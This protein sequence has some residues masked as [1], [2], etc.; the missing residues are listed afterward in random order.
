MESM[1]SSVITKKAYGYARVSTPEQV[2]DH[3]S[4]DNQC[5]RIEEYAKRNNIEIVDW[6]IEEGESAKTAART[7]LH[8]MLE[9]CRKNK[10]NIDHVIVYNVSRISRNLNSFMNDIGSRLS[11][12]GITLRSTMEVIDETPQGKL[13]LNIALSIHQFDNDIKAQTAH[14]N[15]SEVALKG[16][17]ITRAPIGYKIRKVPIG[18]ISSDGHRKER[19]ILVPD[20]SN[21]LA[22]KLTLVLNQFA[23]SNGYMSEADAWRLAVKIGIT[24]PR[25][26]KPIS[27]SCF[28]RLLRQ[29][30]YA[31]Y[32]NSKLVNGELHKLNFNGLISLETHNRIQYILNHDKRIFTPSTDDMY[33]LKGLLICSKCGKYLLG[34]APTSG[35]KK[36]SPRYHCRCKGHGSMAV[37][38]AHSLYEEL[39]E[40]ITPTDGTVKLFKE[41]VS[42]TAAKYLGA[43]NKEIERLN[44]QDEEINQNI[45]RTLN[46]FL[47][48]KSINQ[49][50]KDLFIE[51]LNKERA[52]IE[53]EIE[54]QKEIRQLNEATISY[55]CNFVSK[56]A[57]L[58]RDSDAESR[59]AFQE[60]LFPNGLHI[61]VKEKCFVNCGTEDLSPLYSVIQQK[62]TRKGDLKFNLVGDRGVEPLTS[63]TSKTRSSQ[64]S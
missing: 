63:S 41:I 35:S 15:M 1:D 52:D 26:N 17:W 5:K 46:S 43:A 62:I 21:D 45:A 24:M 56:P 4:L 10:G 30:V 40:Q 3:N 12:Y 49:D 58:W 2:A 33:P 19:S 64:L 9:E 38:D 42:R 20:D 13:M 37:K 32:T 60:I 48:E 6:F 29:P 18:D 28:D 50:E 47:V 39:L 57:K 36:S 23:E 53:R 59:K 54:K 44:K 8:E 31:G 51:K 7:K 11:T 27:F 55:V 14:D 25:T 34:S 22:E 61:D 16:W